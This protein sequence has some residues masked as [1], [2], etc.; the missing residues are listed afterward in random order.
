MQHNDLRR[1]ELRVISSKQCIVHHYF[2]IR[3]IE[4]RRPGLSRVPALQS[5]LRAEARC[6]AL[7]PGLLGLV[8]PCSPR[9]PASSGQC[10]HS[11]EPSEGQSI[12][13]PYVMALKGTQWIYQW[14]GL[15][16]SEG[17]EDAKGAGA[18]AWLWGA[19]G[20]G[21]QGDARPQHHEHSLQHSG[22]RRSSFLLVPA[23][24]EVVGPVAQG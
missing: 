11:G 7:C 18:G 12:P 16:R 6:S 22:V 24:G 17:K 13:V 19:R 2:W 1:A 10:S 21:R 15:K 8:G 4:P 20:G 9:K 14:K 3:K 23:A 5:R